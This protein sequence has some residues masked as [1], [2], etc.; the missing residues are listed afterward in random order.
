MKG[1][2]ICIAG[3]PQGSLQDFFGRSDIFR[4][5][6]HVERGFFG[7]RAVHRQEHSIRPV[8]CRMWD[9]PKAQTLWVRSFCF[10]LF[11]AIPFRTEPTAVPQRLENREPKSTLDPCSLMHV[12]HCGQQTSKFITRMVATDSSRKERARYLLPLHS[13]LRPAQQYAQYRIISESKPSS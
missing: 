2:Q 5:V 1:L 8:P 6:R 12:L 9:T 4:L 11:R 10:V 13:Q 3:D 7:L